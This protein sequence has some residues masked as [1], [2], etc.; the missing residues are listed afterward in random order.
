MP[1][2]E[3]GAF[4][5]LCGGRSRHVHTYRPFSVP[6]QG[7]PL[8]WTQVGGYY[9]ESLT[10]SRRVLSE[11][12]LRVTMRSASS[13][14]AS[15]RYKAWYVAI[16]TPSR[17]METLML[18]IVSNVRRRL[19]QQFFRTRGRN[20]NMQ[21][22]LVYEFPRPRVSGFHPGGRRGEDGSPGHTNGIDLPDLS[23]CPDL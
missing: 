8:L 16:I 3:S 2:T 12:L 17:H 11:I 18:A 21:V 14:G 6:L 5:T 9:R 19:R 4:G 22:F 10:V 1:L 15:L 7:Y 13:G 23:R 20:R